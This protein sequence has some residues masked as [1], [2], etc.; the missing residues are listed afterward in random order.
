MKNLKGTKTE[1]NLKQAF[2]GESEAR[3]KY[4]YFASQAKKDGFVQIS[5]IFE[6]TSNNEKEHA[7]LWFKLIDKIDKIDKN[8]KSSIENEKY[9]AT[10]MY[11]TF[12]KE[13]KEEGFDDIAKMFEEV[14]EVEKEHHDRY[15]ALLNNIENNK[16][17]ESDKEVEWHCLNCGYVYKGK[18][19]PDVCPACAHKKE[20]FERYPKNY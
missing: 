7:K 11:P 3:N 8:L 2:K 14:A 10:I 15:L 9:E 17:F 18:T 16:V 19:A 6:E 1:E 20:Y 4:T 5:K 13:A 12:A